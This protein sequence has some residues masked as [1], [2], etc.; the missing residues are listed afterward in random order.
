MALAK[1]SKR[2]EEREGSFALRNSS[3]TDLNGLIEERI[4]G[5]G[6]QN[7]VNAKT[8]ALVNELRVWKE[9]VARLEQQKERD[10]MARKSQMVQIVKMKE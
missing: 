6:P 7:S 9:K 10:E 4:L 5:N 1:F 8:A 3:P 2:E